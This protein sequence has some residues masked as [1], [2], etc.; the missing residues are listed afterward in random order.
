MIPTIPESVPPR[1]IPKPQET[2]QTLLDQNGHSHLLK[3]NANPKEVT[4]DQKFQRQKKPNLKI[5]RKGQKKNKKKKSSFLP[6][7]RFSRKEP[8]FLSVMTILSQDPPDPTSTKNGVY[9]NRTIILLFH[10]SFAYQPQP[11]F[12]YCLFAFFAGIF[13]GIIM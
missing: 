7:H 9:P 1:P 3:Y 11:S 5:I 2:P 4:R 10:L 6:I 8:Q 12:F 13:L